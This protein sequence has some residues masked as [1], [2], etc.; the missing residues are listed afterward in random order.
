M[1]DGQIGAGSSISTG[2][3]VQKDVDGVWTTQAVTNTASGNKITYTIGV[4]TQTDTVTLDTDNTSTYGSATADD[5][6]AIAAKATVAMD[7]RTS[8]ATVP[9]YTNDVVVTGNVA[10]SLTAAARAGCSSNHLWCF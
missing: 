1:T 3:T 9:V 10:N 5:S 2:V 7:T 8:N 6:D 4:L